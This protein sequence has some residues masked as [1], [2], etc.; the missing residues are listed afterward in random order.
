MIH[1][2]N[3]SGT[4]HVY[5]V[6]L[7]SLGFS[8]SKNKHFSPQ[9]LDLRAW[10]MIQKVSY[11]TKFKSP[12]PHGVLQQLQVSLL[13]QEQPLSTA[14]CDQPFP[15]PKK[16]LPELPPMFSILLLQPT[17]HIFAF[18]YLLFFNEPLNSIFLTISYGFHL[19]FPWL[20]I[21]TKHHHSWGITL[22]CL[23]FWFSI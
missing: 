19:L 16:I 15:P 8:I 4:R 7:S 1:W 10:A 2:I 5:T 18:H 6:H 12:S 22:S 3:K 20:E 21:E 11:Q 23:F 17:I 14:G 9:S 13:N